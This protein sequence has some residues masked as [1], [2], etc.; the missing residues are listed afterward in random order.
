M[1]NNRYIT[2]IKYIGIKVFNWCILKRKYEAK[3]KS[4]LFELNFLSERKVRSEAVKL[5]I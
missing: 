3:P 5:F 1:L 4:F 2:K